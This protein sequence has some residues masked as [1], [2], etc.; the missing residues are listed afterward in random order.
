M[1][2][3]Q[4]GAAHINIFFFLVMLILFLGA[5]GF[6][7]MKNESEAQQR[8]SK[9]EALA[10][11]KV[12][13]GQLFMYQHLV[14]DLEKTIGEA[15]QYAGKEGF[16]YD[17]YGSPA[18]LENVPVPAKLK[19]L[20]QGFAQ[21]AS[22]PESYPLAQFFGRIE[23]S[24]TVYKDKIVAMEGDRTK[25]NGQLAALSAASAKGARDRQDEA[26][27]L[28]TLVTNHT[29]QYESD[30]AAKD[31]LIQDQS[32]NYSS[33][34]REL[35]DT[36]EAAAA[37]ALAVRKDMDLIKARISLMTE[38]S[39]L[40]N[41]PQ[42]ADGIVIEASEL[43]GLAWIN[44]GARDMLQPGTVFSFVEPGS[45]AVKAMGKVVEVSNDNAKVAVYG[46]ANKFDPVVAGD[47]IRNDFYSPDSRRTIYLLGRF[48]YPTP[49]P[50]I[51][52]TLESYGN[53]VVDAIGP[54]VDLVI[55]GDN[56]VNE[57]SSGYTPIE[58]T[59]EFKKVR[60]YGIETATLN[61]VRSL[62]SQ[63]K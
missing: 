41:P 19:A 45:S 11:A 22:V 49:R 55:V 3:S 31:Q 1:P 16:N 2:T 26:S 35:T 47:E 9:L 58:D 17:D 48:G 32:A 25:L 54:E 14:E 50:M 23:S 29:S 38:R 15:G 56:P 44:I 28:N 57:D 7:Y 36:K 42:T 63:V 33:I 27:K 62:L 13:E 53:K 4:R 20:M 59:E 39:R 12:L 52:K 34:R 51:R 37:D 24:M 8:E 40:I 46:V 61:K 10:A 30:L 5:G 60:F 18:P 43:T 6:G 21:K